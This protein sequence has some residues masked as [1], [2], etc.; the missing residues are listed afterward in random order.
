M[1]GTT[2]IKGGH[3]QHYAMTQDMVCMTFFLENVG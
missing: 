3:P 1:V 2:V